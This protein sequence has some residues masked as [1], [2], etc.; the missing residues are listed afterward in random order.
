MKSPVL[1]NWRRNL[2][3]LAA[4][5]AIASLGVALLTSGTVCD[6]EQRDDGGFLP[7]AESADDVLQFV[8]SSDSPLDRAGRMN[9]LYFGRRIPQPGWAGVVT[10]L[11]RLEDGQWLVEVA[12]R[13]TSAVIMARSDESLA[14]LRPGQA[15]TVV[16]RIVG[17]NGC[18]TITLGDATVAIE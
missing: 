8:C 18:Q 5:A 2:G 14:H 9:D 1:S 7:T 3:S 17:V 11:R 12:E 16:G 10:S 4:L 15:V 6:R 13:G